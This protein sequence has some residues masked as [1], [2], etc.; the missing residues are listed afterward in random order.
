MPSYNQLLFKKSTRMCKSKMCNVKALRKCPQKK[1]IV[2]KLRI[3][4]PKKPNSAQ[5]KIAKVKV[6]KRAVLAYIPG[7]GHVLKS[8]SEVLVA[9]GRANDLPG[10][11][12][13]LIRGKFDFS[14]KELFDRMKK[15]SK[16]GYKSKKL[17]T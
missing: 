3:V 12:F 10:V 14:Y 15:K 6:F 2:F 8:Y 1:G 7:Q 4:K 11:R 9:G 13:S 5:R 16:Y 17:W